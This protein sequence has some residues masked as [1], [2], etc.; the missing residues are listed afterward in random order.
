[1]GDKMFSIYIIAVLVSWIVVHLI[2]YII[3]CKTTKKYT[4]SLAIL[5][6]GG[7][8]SAHTAILSSVTML[9]GLKDGFDS[10][11]FALAITVLLIVM[12]DAVRVRRSTGEQG[13]AINEMIKSQKIDIKPLKISRGHKPIEVAIGFILGVLIGVIVF[14]ATK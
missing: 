6:S 12:H 7:M 2:K 10:G 3:L 5:E 14:L 4:L 9:I 13:L 11:L 1:M 8:P